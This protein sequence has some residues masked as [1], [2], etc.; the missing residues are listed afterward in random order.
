MV[1]T[2]NDITTK[3]YQK[4]SIQVALNGLSFCVFNQ[5]NNTIIDFKKI[6]FPENN[7][8]EEELWHIFEKHK[9]LSKKYDE[10]IILHDNNLN[11]FV[12]KSLFN[13][14]HLGS[15]LQYTTK[16]YPTDVFAFDTLKNTEINNVYVPYV[17]INNFFIDQYGSFTYKN[18]NTI[19]VEQ[20]LCFSIKEN[21]KQMF[22]HQTTTTL[23]IVVAEN[24]NLLF[25]NSFTYTTVQDFVYYVLF[26]FQQLQLNAEKTPVFFLGNTKK[27]DEFFTLIYTYVR[28]CELLNLE[29]ESKKINQ[30]EATV[31]NNF[32]LFYS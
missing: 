9:I 2:T 11:T 5:L 8:I 10:I 3:T 18:K 1:K 17:H 12:P 4:L 23:E 7:V 13:P 25:F 26:V 32:I 14:E 15:Y 30:L 29:E 20:L 19:L 6:S 24:G 31:R 21:K 22:I 28:H 16:V 27:H